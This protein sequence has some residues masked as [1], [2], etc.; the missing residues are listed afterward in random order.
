MLQ[1][2]YFGLHE[3]KWAELKNKKN[4]KGSGWY[5]GSHQVFDSSYIEADFREFQWKQKNDLHWGGEAEYEAQAESCQ[6]LHP[7]R[8]SIG[9]STGWA[10]ILRNRL[11]LSDCVCIRES[12][13]STCGTGLG[14]SLT[15]P[16]KVF[17]AGG[18]FVLVIIRAAHVNVF[19][20]LVF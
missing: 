1:N 12:F 20:L 16:Q 13:E 17:G 5:R 3:V 15:A 14:Q 9:M 6:Q 19:F 18:A 2:D 11:S 7:E 8:S 10:F 4:L